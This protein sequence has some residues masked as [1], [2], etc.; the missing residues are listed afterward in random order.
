[1]LSSDILYTQEVLPFSS[2]KLP[3]LDRKLAKESSANVNKSA[4]FADT[5]ESV[6]I[7]ILEGKGIRAA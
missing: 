6:L 3:H 4:V 1:M 2:Y 5:A 7:E